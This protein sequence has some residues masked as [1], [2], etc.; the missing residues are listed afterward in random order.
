MCVQHNSSGVE[1]GVKVAPCLLL[2]ACFMVGLPVNIAVIFDICRNYKSY[3]SKVNPNIL[4]L[5]LNLALV[6]SVALTTSP[7]VLYT[8]FWGFT[9]GDATCQMMYFILT[10]C[11]F[12]SVVTVTAISIN[13]FLIVKLGVANPRLMAQ[14]SRRRREVVFLGGVWALALLFSIS[15]L[16]TR[17]EIDTQD[18]VCHL[19]RAEQAPAA[20]KRLKLFRDPAGVGM[21]SLCLLNSTINPFLYAFALRRKLNRSQASSKNNT[22]M[23]TVMTTVMTVDMTAVS[24]SPN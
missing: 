1:P 11:L 16:F 2:G 9:F 23:S 5:V 17:R 6:D 13:Y 15:T 20:Y 8:L 21:K 18:P 12:I 22:G 10:S 19:H 24:E 3:T 4:L 7:L 14:V